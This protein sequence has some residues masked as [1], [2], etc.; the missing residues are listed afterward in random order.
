MTRVTIEQLRK[1]TE[2]QL[3]LAKTLGFV[4]ENLEQGVC[5][6]RAVYQK[7][8]LRP[9]NTISGPVQMALAD[10]AMW[11]A[12]MSKRERVQMALTTNFNINFLRRPEPD[13]IIAVA[14]IIKLGRRLAVGTV[15]LFGNSEQELVAHVTCTYSLPPEIVKEI[16]K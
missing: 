3:P 8:F 10:Y 6:V 16:S 14:K 12:I 4:V 7:D 13:D 11:G 9:G 5:V 2:D 1:V 15:D